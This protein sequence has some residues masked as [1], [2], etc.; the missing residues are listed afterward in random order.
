MAMPIIARRD[1]TVEMLDALPDDGQ[2]HEIIDGERFVTPSPVFPHQLVLGELYARVRAYMRGTT[3]GRVGF[4]PSDIRR[5]DRSRNRVQPDLFVVRLDGRALPA[6]P[7]GFADVL[8]AVEVASPSNLRY[9]YHTKRTLYLQGG[10]PEYWVVN[11][12][13]RNISRWRTMADP[14]AVLSRQI[15]WHPAGIAEPLI[16]DIEELFR[17]ALD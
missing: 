8:L 3:V 15:E 13:A 5:G 16:I 4:S 17:E 11:L 9:D 2:R 1:W 7:F 12:D 14:G 6:A 10:V